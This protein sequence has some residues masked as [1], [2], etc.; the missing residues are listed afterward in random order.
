MRNLF[1]ELAQTGEAGIKQLV[2][3]RAQENVELEFK[4]KVNPRNGELTKDDRKNLGIILSALSN[5]KGGIVIWG[6]SAAKNVDDI[7]C[8][9]RIEP[10]FEID[11]FRSEVERAISQA[12]MP[13]MRV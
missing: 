1:D 10:I 3:Q 8:A 2:D 4:A 6:V 11:K 12:I 5:S 9:S 13:V 7:D